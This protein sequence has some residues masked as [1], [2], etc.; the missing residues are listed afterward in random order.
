MV[1]HSTLT[2][3]RELQWQTALFTELLTKQAA[4]NASPGAKR[5]DHG[6]DIQG[7]SCYTKRSG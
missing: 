6:G 3:K 1:L 2:L 5:L 7:Y 4:A